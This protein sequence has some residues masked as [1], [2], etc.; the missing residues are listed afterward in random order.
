METLCL[1]LDDELYQQSLLL[2]EV[3]LMETHANL[4][5]KRSAVL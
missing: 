4:S 1:V 5:V 3:E 2:L